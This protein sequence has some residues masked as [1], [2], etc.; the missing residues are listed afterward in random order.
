MAESGPSEPSETTPQLVE[1]NSATRALNILGDRWA[2]VILY[3]A[4]LGIKRFEDFKNR[5]GLARS[6]L[7]NRLRRLHAAGVLEVAVYQERP[8]REEYRLTAMG[9]D[10]YRLALMI[11][12]WEKRWFY[13]PENPAHRLKHGCGHEFTPEFRCGHCGELVSPRDVYAETEYPRLSGWSATSALIDDR[14]KVIDAPRAEPVHA[15]RHARRGPGI[16]RAARSDV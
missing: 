5:I 16:V 1:A 9:R 4:F 2:L 13:D 14:W 8:V 7:I 11:I 15:A 10:L 6:L 3:L 12:R